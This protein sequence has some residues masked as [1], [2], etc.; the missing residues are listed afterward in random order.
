MPSFYSESVVHWIE[1]L[2]SNRA[3]HFMRPYISRILEAS[4]RGADEQATLYDE[5]TEINAQAAPGSSSEPPIDFTGDAELWR[6][7]AAKYRADLVRITVQ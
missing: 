2:A 7:R 5:Y 6:E 1:Y 3:H 4:I